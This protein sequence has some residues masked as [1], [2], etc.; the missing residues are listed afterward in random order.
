MPVLAA[1]KTTAKSTTATSAT[2]TN[3][4]KASLTTSEAVTQS[5]NADKT[6]ENGMIVELKTKDPTSVVPVPQTDVSKILGIV[7]PTASATIVLTPQNI[8]QQQVLV[9]TAG[10]YKVLVS[11]QNGPI[12]VGDFITVSAIAGVGMKADANETEVIGKAA[13]VFSGTNNVLGSVSLKDSTGKQ[14]KVSVSEITIDMDISH[15]PL[16]QMSADYVPGFLSNVAI[17]VASK[18]VSVARIYIATVILLITMLITG[19]MLY[20]GVRSGMIAVGRNPLS[21]KSIIK[22][23]IE[24][25]AAGLIIFVVGIIAVYLLLKL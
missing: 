11:N 14:I 15:N 17:A 2:N 18:P 9:A 5:Y 6:V 22:S 24:T 19:N 3:N 12:N 7:I 23:L 1:T 4:T 13:A 8:T 21:K 16:Y 20:S 25:V 10:S